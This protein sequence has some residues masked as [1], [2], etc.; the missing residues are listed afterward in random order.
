MAQDSVTPTGKIA[1]ADCGALVPDI[2]RLI[3]SIVTFGLERRCV[4]RDDFIFEAWRCKVEGQNTEISPEIFDWEI[5]VDRAER[6]KLHKKKQ[7]YRVRVQ[8]AF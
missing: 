4:P 8:E 1:M 6:T 3:C 5:F 7:E 2:L